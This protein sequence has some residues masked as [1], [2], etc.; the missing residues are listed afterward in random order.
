MSQMTAIHRLLAGLPSDE[1]AFI[2]S[3]HE[4]VTLSPDQLICNPGESITQ[5]YMP[6]EGYVVMTAGSDAHDALGVGLIGRDG[7]TGASLIL[8]VDRAPLRLRVQDGGSALR[9]SAADFLDCVAACPEF[10]LRVRAALYQEINFL[11]HTAVC[12]VFH[13][14]DVRLA[15]WLLMVQDCL[16]RADFTLTHDRLARMLGVRRSGVTTAAGV[17]QHRHLITY[18][19]GHIEILDRRG[20][21]KASCSCFRSLRTSRRGIAAA[22]RDLPPPSDLPPVA[23]RVSLPRSAGP[24]A[25]RHLDA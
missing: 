19:R 6:L 24:S 11:A 5:V 22:L 14:V 8:G 23:S 9:F 18:S 15:Y 20:L 4:T 13:V 7:L 10:N 16:G 21:E 25:G 3:R 1:V 12:A 2:A 17:L